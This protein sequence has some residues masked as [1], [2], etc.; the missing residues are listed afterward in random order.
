M[1][2]T[3]VVVLAVLAVAFSAYAEAAKPRKRSRNADRIG[4]YAVGFAGQTTYTSDGTEDEGLATEI[5]LSFDSSDERNLS[6]STD[7]SGLGYQAAFGYRFNRHL[8]AELT[9]LQLGEMVSTARGELDFGTGFQPSSTELAFKAGGP[10]VSALGILPISDRLEFFGRVGYLF[11]SSRRELRARIGDERGNLGS[12]R[13]NSQDLILG[14][15]FSVHFGQVYSLRV[16]YLRMGEV[17]DGDS[18]SE[19]ANMIGAGLVVRF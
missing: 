1:K 4:P 16:E 9:L 18:G 5:L 15:G 11:A 8:A 12:G 6:S 14:A 10:M 13:G 3:P 2:K 17:G 19:E 7:D